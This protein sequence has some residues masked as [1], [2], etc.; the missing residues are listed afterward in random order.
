MCSAL[1]LAENFTGN[2]IDLSCYDAKKDANACEAAST[3]TKFGLAASGKLYKL[4]ETGN[5]KA[6]EAMRS[7]ADRSADPNKAAK[8]GVIAKVT[9]SKGADDTLKVETIEVQ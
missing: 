7:R 8:G 6:A 5:S 9:G 3:T 4:D 1:A 2:L